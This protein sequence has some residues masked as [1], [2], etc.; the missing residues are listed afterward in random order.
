VCIAIRENQVRTGREAGFAALYGSGGA[1][2]AL[3]HEH[4]GDAGTERLRDAAVAGRFAT[5]DHWTI[6]H[7]T[8]AAAYDACRAAATPRDAELDAQG[9]ALS[10]AERLVGR[11]D[12]D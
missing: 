4:E 6:D 5:I 8:C 12:R 3:F 7:W 9:D 11:F 1:W 2:V 10:I